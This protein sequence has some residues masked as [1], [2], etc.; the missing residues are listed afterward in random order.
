MQ[1]YRKLEVWRLAH[2]LVLG[3]YKASNEFPASETFA[4]TR[5]LRRSAVSIGSNIVEGAGRPSQKEFRHFLG[6][7]RASCVETDYQLLIARDLGYMSVGTYGDL[8]GNADRIRRMLTSL[9]R[10]AAAS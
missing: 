2:T 7:A 8:S 10:A 3:V 6:I 9:R 5:Q 1:D 4:L